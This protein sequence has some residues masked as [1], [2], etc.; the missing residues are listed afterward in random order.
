M[1]CVR[2]PIAD[3]INVLTRLLP[4]RETGDDRQHNYAYHYALDGGLHVPLIAR[5][6][7]RWLNGFDLDSRPDVCLPPPAPTD[8]LADCDPP[9]SE[10]PR[11]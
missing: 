11:E 8:S 5:S 6:V 7:A 1:A 2:S 10:E 3:K 4:Q 9:Q